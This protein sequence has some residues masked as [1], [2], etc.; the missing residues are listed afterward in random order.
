VP[1]C[2]LESIMTGTA[3]FIPVVMPRMPEAKKDVLNRVAQGGVS[4]YADGA[5]VAGGALAA[6]VDVVAVVSRDVASGVESNRDIESARDVTAERVGADGDI[7]VPDGISLHRAAADGRV[8]VSGGVG[9]E[10]ADTAAGVVVTRGAALHAV[11]AG[12]RIALPCGVIFQ[13]LT[14][15]SESKLTF[16]VSCHSGAPSRS[17][18]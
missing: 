15:P 6:D 9:P 8:V 7:E 5:V 13:R 4:A 16:C 3:L 10:D 17:S 12:G 2:P 18:R 14:R 1:N 11:N